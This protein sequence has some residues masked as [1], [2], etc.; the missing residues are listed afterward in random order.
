MNVGDLVRWAGYE[1][2]TGQTVTGVGYLA[3][4]GAGWARVVE[5]RADGDLYHKLPREWV[6]P[7]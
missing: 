4:E 2:T 6:A 5:T 7:R 3:S 1:M